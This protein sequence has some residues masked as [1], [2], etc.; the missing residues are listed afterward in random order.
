MTVRGRQNRPI[1]EP[2]IHRLLP[3]PNPLLYFSDVRVGPTYTRTFDVG[4]GGALVAPIRLAPLSRLQHQRQRIPEDCQVVPNSRSVRPAPPA[5]IP[6]QYTQPHLIPQPALF[7]FIT[8]KGLAI[9][10]RNPKVGSVHRQQTIPANISHLPVFKL[11][12]EK[13]DSTACQLNLK[14]R[15]S[16]QQSNKR[17]TTV[18]FN[19]KSDRIN[20]HT[21]LLMVLGSLPPSKHER[22]VSFAGYARINASA[23]KK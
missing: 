20:G 3:A 15:T 16:K 1:F 11:N 7:E 8:P 23:H 6:R 14:I 10:H 5:D 13:K 2:L 12:L 17:L 18:S 21:Y 4:W 19:K 9:S 22:E